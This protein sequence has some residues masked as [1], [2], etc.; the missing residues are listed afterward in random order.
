MIIN[1]LTIQHLRNIERADLDFSSTVNIVTGGNGAGKTTLLEAIYLLARA[2]SF[3]IGNQ[4]TPIQKGKERLLLYAETLDELK[5]EHRIGL[6][7]KGS[8]T[9][10]RI[11]GR[12]I[13][14]VSELARLLPIALVTPM[15][16]RILEEGPRNRRR[17]INWGLFHVEHD[18]KGLMADFS[19]SLLQRN[20]ALRRGGKELS[21]WDETFA[22]CAEN[23][24]VRQERYFE[25]LRS[26]LLSLC[27]EIYFLKKLE[28]SFNRGWAQGDDLR[29]AIAKRRT[30]DRENGYTHAG[31]QRSD[32]LF[33]IDGAPIR[34][35]LSRGQQKVLI[36]LIL[37]SQ[38]KLLEQARGEKPVFLFDDLQSELDQDSVE[39]ICGL[40]NR[41]QLQT[42][43]T[44]LST[45]GILAMPWSNEPRLF[46]VEHGVF[47]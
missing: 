17:L 46:H 24:S 23:V 15:S 44:S 2:K 1:R 22:Q 32:L 16:H 31:P 35:I 14:R 19:K 9:R 21:V 11:D 47:V 42:V 45:K 33:K 37:I 10:L 38:A 36:A 41:Q 30:Q 12:S 4:A 3:R 8:Q 27:G 5:I 20:N 6:E 26:H 40:L 39:L 7:K 43:I 29:E 28:L 18:F 34:Q 13:I 25:E